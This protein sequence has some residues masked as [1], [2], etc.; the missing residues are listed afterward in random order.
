MPVPLKT[1]FLSLGLLCVYTTRAQNKISLR[2]SSE[3]YFSKKTEHM[4][5]MTREWQLY[6]D[7]ALLIDPT[8]DEMWQT[9][10]M[11]YLKSGN[12]ALAFRYYDKAVDL[13]PKRWL[14]YRAFCK[15]MFLKDY[16]AAL[17]DFEKAGQYPD[18]PKYTMDHTFYFYQGLC[19]LESNQPANAI[20]L[21][22]KSLNQ[23][24][25]DNSDQS[26]H[27]LDLFYLGLAHYHS[28][29]MANAIRFLKQAEAK[30]TQLPDVLYYLAIIYHQQ[31][32]FLLAASYLKKAQM[33]F[34][35]EYRFTEDN[36]FYVNYPRQISRTELNELAEKLGQH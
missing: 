22:E 31:K 3:S 25:T 32:N 14:A 23:Q 6:A 2:D 5:Y 12:Y 9:K 1:L 21:F 26:V 19:Y 17:I 16:S 34:D 13:N 35:Q 27:Y 33:G 18:I 36:I 30:Y 10:G 4:S 11:P 8:N 24:K 29:D 7:S 28:G 15:A 20:P